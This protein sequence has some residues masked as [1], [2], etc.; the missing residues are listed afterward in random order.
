MVKSSE[1]R[2]KT[3]AEAEK[4]LLGTPAAEAPAATFFRPAFSCRDTVHGMQP[5]RSRRPHETRRAV[6]WPTLAVAATIYGGFAFLTWLYEALPWWLLVP[7]GGGIVAWHG[8]LQHEVVHGHP[9]R[10]R[11][12]NELLVLPSLWLW[13][14]YHLYRRSHLAHH[15]DTFLTDPQRDPESYYV[16]AATWNHCGPLFRAFLWIHNTVAGRLL[17]G[18]PWAVMRL[19]LSEGQHLVRGNFRS[20]GAWAWHIVGSALVLG[21]VVGVCAIPVEAYIALFAYPGLAL[22]LLRSYLEHRAHAAVPARTA[23]VEA[24][25]VMSLMYLYNNLHVVHHRYPAMAW[26][27]I[28]KEYRRRRKEFLSENGG[29]VIPGGYGE[30]VARYLLWPKEAPV[31]PSHAAAAASPLITRPAQPA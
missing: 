9:T 18:P 29:Y 17:L 25:P 24:G 22:T 5:A 11:R 4:A 8:S 15:N 26:Y 3:S 6:E 1:G 12:F 14:P 20:L 13:L 10:W 19:C 7:L 23:I 27:D 21:W 30:V 28:P 31:H 16:T 2:T